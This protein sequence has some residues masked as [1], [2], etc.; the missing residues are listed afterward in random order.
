MST[1]YEQLKHNLEYLKMEEM[2]LYLDEI[3]DIVSHNQLSFVYLVL[4]NYSFYIIT[5]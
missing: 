5:I 2:K 1:T 3:L 4:L